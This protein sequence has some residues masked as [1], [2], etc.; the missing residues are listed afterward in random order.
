MI[1]RW[2]VPGVATVLIGTTASVLATSGPIQ[3]DIGARAHAALANATWAEVAIAGRDITI[4]GIATT[5]EQ[6][7]AAVG[8]LSGTHGVRS[9][10]I[11]ALS[12]PLA[13]PFTFSAGVENGAVALRGAIVDEALRPQLV[14]LSSATQDET[15]LRSGAPDRAQWQK[16][17]EFGL[18]YLPFLAH[19]ELEMNGLSLRLSGQARSPQDFDRLVELTPPAGADVRI[20]IAPAL[21]S[22]YE[23]RAR[24]DSG[25][26]VVSGFVPRADM[27]DRLRVASAN[28]IPVATGLA[29][30]SGAPENFEAQALAAIR[31]LSTLEQGHAVLEDGR[32][33][34]RGQ[35]GSVQVAQAA[36]ETMEATGGA[37]ALDPAPI[38]DY[39]LTVKVDAA[40]KLTFDGY[41]P[42]DAAKAKLAALPKADVSGLKIGA[43][44]AARFD[45]GLEFGLKALAHLKNGEFEIRGT[46]LTLEG[47]AVSG[48]DYRAVM[49]QIEEGAPQGT[50]L[51]SATITPPAASPYV[52]LVAHGVDGSFHLTGS[53]PDEATRQK[54][55]AIIGK[56]A[57]NT[58]DLASGAPEGF[59]A[60][61]EIGLEALKRLD[62][63]RL[64]YD[65]TRWSLSGT[66]ATAAIKAEI[67][68][69]LAEQSAK[70]GWHLSILARPAPANAAPAAT[71][72]AAPADAAPSMATEAQAATPAPDAEPAAAEPA[73]AEPAAEAEQVA[74][75]PAAEAAPMAAAQ[76]EAAAPK[77]DYTFAASRIDGGAIAMSGAVPAEGTKAFLSVVAGNAPTT[78]LKVLDN[79]PEGYIGSVVAG[80]RALAL[81]KDAQLGFDGAAW[82]LKGKAGT[83]G[84]AEK[85]RAEIAALPS[86]KE[87]MLDIAGPPP[88]EVCRAA[89]AEFAAH[90]SIL[91]KSGSAI[92]EPESAVALD[93]AARDLALCPDAMVHVE[94]HTDADGPDD[95]NLAL[96][97]ARAEAVIAALVAD[98]VDERRLY[99]VGYGES[100]PIADNDTRAGKQA[101]RRIVFTVLDK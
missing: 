32:I 55:E 22:P 49:A 79:P 78:G 63:G 47:L 83:P 71:T 92:L 12:A 37:A 39:W 82:S 95:T 85:A 56:A 1:L 76:T 5:D 26:I 14:A 97:V 10:S 46:T 53:V 81:L 61:A 36:T 75:P 30:G 98:G 88:I 23:W 74:T 77:T 96:S 40:G 59:A 42:D 90:T 65:G 57:T 48:T 20:D 86:G 38:A 45:S 11:A 15:A 35:P 66:A 68:Q 84:N 29:L 21:V 70:G 27:P 34:V 80:V 50:E 89:L 24:L 2:L 41:V 52:W 62:A 6:I 4:S 33:V 58:V 7:A 100:M 31:V 91:F 54:T 51:A 18:S 3:A 17:A 101:N 43:G 44:A 60:N 8:R 87:W 13:D 99:A 25:R 19:G 64:G 9:V 67:E 72:D 73:P 94:G 69:D 28:D 93:V 16:I